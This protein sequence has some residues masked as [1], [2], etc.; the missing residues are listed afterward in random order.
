MELSGYYV[1]LLDSWACVR[2][3]D[4]NGMPT[5]DSTLNQQQQ[6]VPTT[7]QTLLANGA[8][9]T[10]NPLGGNHTVQ[11]RLGVCAEEA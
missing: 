1:P 3:G 8:L 2:G 10:T 4:A 5:L 7:N 6:Y 11:W 9:R